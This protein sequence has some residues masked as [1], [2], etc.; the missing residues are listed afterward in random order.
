MAAR[1]MTEREKKI[2]CR[3]EE[4]MAGGRLNPAGQAPAQQ[5]EIHRGSPG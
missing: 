2:P 4:K 5:E 3:A 1:K